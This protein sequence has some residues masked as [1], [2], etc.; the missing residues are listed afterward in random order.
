MVATEPMDDVAIAQLAKL[1]GVLRAGGVTKFWTADMNL[2]LMPAKY[3]TVSV[4]P[5]EGSAEGEPDF[6]PGKAYEDAI[7]TA[8]KA[9]ATARA[10][11]G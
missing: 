10:K 6:D 1:V 11:E 7:E 4:A 2:E 5:D 8:A 3:P 9:I